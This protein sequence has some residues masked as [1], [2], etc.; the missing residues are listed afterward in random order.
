MAE[1]HMS[2]NQI[3]RSTAGQDRGELF[4]VWAGGGRAVLDDGKRRKRLRPKQKTEEIRARGSC[5]AD[6][7]TRDEISDKSSLQAVAPIAAAP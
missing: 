4:L 2:G 7:D 1:G 6:A 5:V 3:V